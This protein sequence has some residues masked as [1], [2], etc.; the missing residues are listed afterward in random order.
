[1]QNSLNKF[2]NHHFQNMSEEQTHVS[3]L[4]ILLCD[5]KVFVKIENN[6]E[7][8]SIKKIYT[9][10]QEFQNVIFKSIN[11]LEELKTNRSPN[12]LKH[13]STHRIARIQVLEDAILLYEAHKSLPWKISKI[14]G[15]IESQAAYN[16]NDISFLTQLYG[17]GSTYVPTST[18]S[19]RRVRTCAN[20][21]LSSLRK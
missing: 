19:Q 2:I 11:D 5:N 14:T 3:S 8:L 17:I 6:W 7:Y 9:L 18:Q 12:I 13:Y 4:E 1:M 15:L 21:K 10:S 16:E 20:T